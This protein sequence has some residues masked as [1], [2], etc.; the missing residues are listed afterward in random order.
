MIC[1]VW[2][3]HF[4]SGQQI[5]RIVRGAGKG[6]GGGKQSAP[7][8]SSRK[9]IQSHTPVWSQYTQVKMGVYYI[10]THFFPTK[11][12]FSF[13]HLWY[14]DNAAIPDITLMRIAFFL[15]TII[16]FL[17]FCLVACL[18]R[19]WTRWSHS[20]PWTFSSKR[21]SINSIKCSAGSQKE[22]KIMIISSCCT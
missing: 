13:Q 12:S 4:C 2:L 11:F 16:I 9:R 15:L 1:S 18:S 14:I 7:P 21:N 3:W 20:S 17:L 8:F 19:V 6:D 10:G 5:N 22:S